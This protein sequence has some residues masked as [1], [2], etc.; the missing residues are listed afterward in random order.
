MSSEPNYQ[1]SDP[2][3]KLTICETKKMNSFCDFFQNFKK[4]GLLKIQISKY[5]EWSVQQ[6]KENK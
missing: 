4:L 2:R 3:M 1:H 5:F 6:N